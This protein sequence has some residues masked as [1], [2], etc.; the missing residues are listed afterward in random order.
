MK[1]EITTAVLDAMNTGRHDLPTVRH[2]RKILEAAGIEVEVHP[3]E[4]AEARRL[5]ELVAD[6]L[7]EADALD[8]GQ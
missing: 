7:A 8:G 5:R 3:M 1:V 2:A 4:R 6:T